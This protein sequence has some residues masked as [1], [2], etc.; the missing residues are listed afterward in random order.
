MIRLVSFLLPL[1]L[2]LALPAHAVY[3][4]VDDKGVTHYGDTMPPQ[5][6]NKAVTQMNNKGSVVKNIDAPLTAEQLKAREVEA[7]RKKAEEKQGIE[8]KRMDMAL[9]DTY[10]SEKEFDLAREREVAQMDARL[11]GLRPALEEA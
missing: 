1:C 11:E 5:C 6:A 2:A 4:C 8:L 9:L 7:M 10:T 3:K